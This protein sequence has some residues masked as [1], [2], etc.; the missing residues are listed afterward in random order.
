MVSH[1]IFP[2]EPRLKDLI[3]GKLLGAEEAEVAH[4]IEDCEKC[5]RA[6]E[7]LAPARDELLPPHVNGAEVQ[8]ETRE[9]ALKQAMDRL[10]ADGNMEIE[11][12]SEPMSDNDALKILSTSD[13][14][15]SLGRLGLYEVTE[16]IGRGGMGT[17]F[18]AIDVTL[19][20]I[21]A[22]IVLSPS[23]ASNG[24]ARKPLR[25]FGDE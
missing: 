20:R 22:V 24:T 25:K 15:D 14:A 10:H 13:K 4:H 16:I 12:E 11:A 17:V 9:Q 21:V 7:Q 5:Q 18:K 6:V 23:L 2:P 19:D 8:L 3:E 1:T